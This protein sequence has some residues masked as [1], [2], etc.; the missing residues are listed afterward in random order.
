VVGY[1]MR[2]T[3]LKPSLNSI[4]KARLTAPSPVFVKE[5]M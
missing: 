5:E 2:A 4:A 3:S 1:R